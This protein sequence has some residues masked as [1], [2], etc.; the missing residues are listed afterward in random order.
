MPHPHP[1]PSTGS[2]WPPPTPSTGSTAAQAYEERWH[3][4]P[5]TTPGST[6]CPYSPSYANH[7]KPVGTLLCPPCVHNTCY[8]L[9]DCGCK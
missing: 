3:L 7:S 4:H 2:P 9:C 5:P 6:V 1:T 8:T